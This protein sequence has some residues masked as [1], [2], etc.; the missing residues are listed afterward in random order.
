MFNPPHPAE[1]LRDH[2]GKMSVTDAAK[3]LDVTRVA[4]SLILNG[5]AGISSDVVLGLSEA[6]RSSAELWIGMKS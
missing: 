3:D 2:L 4:L 6:L 1:L 5:S